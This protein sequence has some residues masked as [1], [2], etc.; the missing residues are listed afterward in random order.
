MSFQS[1]D[2]VTRF[3]G[4]FRPA[5]IAALRTVAMAGIVLTIVYCIF[6]F[7]EDLNTG[8]LRR[9]ASYIEQLTFDEDPVDTFTFDAGTAS[10]YAP[11]DVGVAICAGGS[12]RFVPPFADM[13]YSCRI[14]YTDPRLAP[15]GQFVYVYDLGGRGISRL[16]SY[17]L[18]D[19][20][21]LDSDIISLSVNSSGQCAVVTNEAGYRTAVTVFGKHLK[22]QFKW[23]TSEHFAFLSALSP[24]GGTAAVLCLGQ[25]DGAPNLYIR[26]QPTSGSECKTTVE[27]GD[28]NVYDM[29]Y[30]SNSRL[31]VVG[32]RGVQVFD[33]AGK[34][35]GS[36]EIR[37]GTLT[38]CEL[39]REG[40]CALAVKAEKGDSTRVFVLDESCQELWSGDVRGAVRYMALSDDQLAFIAHDGV[41]RVLLPEGEEAV[42]A[43]VG[44]R[45]VLITET[46]SVAA[47]YSDRAQ[48]VSF[49]AED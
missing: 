24:D 6:N 36:L 5:V 7:Q 26:Y 20:I 48:L 30:L 22:E 13:E 23:Q 46:G 34:L 44:M 28:M 1:I 8:N 12:F 27:L 15:C 18:L 4:D 25:K 2:N 19:E 10:S 45:D 49:E 43:M 40:W 32:D 35:R 47:V 39:R 37:S 33:N 17:S 3:R 11:F 9:I 31:M 38:S 41:H 29:E 42:R 14:K 16:N 21:T